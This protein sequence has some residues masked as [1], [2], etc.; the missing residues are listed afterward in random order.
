MG[1]RGLGGGGGGGLG[2]GGG[3]GVCIYVKET[4]HVN[5]RADLM[6]ENTVALLPYFLIWEENDDGHVE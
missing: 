6:F 1:G 5:M 3:G 4:M 2:G